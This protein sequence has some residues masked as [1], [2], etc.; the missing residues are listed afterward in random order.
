MRYPQH[1]GELLDS[2]IVNGTAN[3]AYDGIAFFADPSGVRVNDNLL[4][5]TISAATPTLAQAA[6]DVITMRKAMMAFTDDKGKAVATLINYS[7]HANMLCRLTSKTSAD[8]PGWTSR[9]GG[10]SARTSRT[11]W[12]N[13]VRDG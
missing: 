2:L 1:K 10:G 13:F 7:A 12:D 8:W 11:C 3:L 4:A 6:A 9:A 5:G